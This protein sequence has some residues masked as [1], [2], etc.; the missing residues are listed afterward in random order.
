MV[1]Q[2]LKR[3][4]YDQWK[5]KVTVKLVRAYL[6]GIDELT[7][8]RLML[9]KKVE[10]FRIMQLDVKKFETD[11]SRFR[12][13]PDNAEGESSVQRLVWAMNTVKNQHA[14]FERLLIDLKQSM[15]A[16]S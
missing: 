16:V 12:K 9:Q 8:I 11:D 7:T 5:P 2:D 4:R 14:C 6:S 3:R 15:D 1:I 10:L 13:T